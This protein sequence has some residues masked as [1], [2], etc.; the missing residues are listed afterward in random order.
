MNGGCFDIFAYQAA[1]RRRRRPAS[2]PS[3]AATAASIKSPSCAENNV[4][5][6]RYLTLQRRAAVSPAGCRAPNSHFLNLL[7]TRQQ[8]QH[9]DTH[10]QRLRVNCSLQMH[11]PGEGRDT[12]RET[13]Q[14]PPGNPAN[15]LKLWLS[16]VLHR[17]NF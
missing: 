14:T 2:H 9:V 8:Q 6:A 7:Q 4:S 5:P 1:Q 17:F 3:A 10:I 11:V 12:H 13:M 15:R 16:C